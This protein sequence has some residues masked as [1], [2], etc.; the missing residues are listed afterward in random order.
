MVSVQLQVLSLPLNRVESIYALKSQNHNLLMK[1]QIIQK[2]ATCR[3][4][5]N[6]GIFCL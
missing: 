3:H 5:P 6:G 2:K 1:L 4:M